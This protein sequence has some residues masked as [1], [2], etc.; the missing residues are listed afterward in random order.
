MFGFK[1]SFDFV[2]VIVTT[3]F[4]TLMGAFVFMVGDILGKEMAKTVEQ[5]FGGQE[6][7]PASVPVKEEANS[8][9]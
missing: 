6:T 9:S 5:F 2:D 1:L 8:C 7:A 4:L 3:A